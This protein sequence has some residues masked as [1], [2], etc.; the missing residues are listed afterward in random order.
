MSNV[1]LDAS[2]LLALIQD[3][4]GADVVKEAG[5]NAVIS[6]LNLAEAAA[7]AVDAQGDYR[8]VRDTVARFGIEVVPFDLSQAYSS[9]ILRRRTRGVPLSLADRACLALALQRR[10]P[11]L[12]ADRQWARLNIGIDIQRVRTT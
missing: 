11:V 1:V 3:E 10:L 8:T 6:T 7:H 4:P 2:A 12:T 9:A 5:R